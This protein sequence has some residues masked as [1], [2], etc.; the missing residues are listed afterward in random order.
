MSRRESARYERYE[1]RLLE[2]L[3]MLLLDE[4]VMA[5]EHGWSIVWRRSGCPQ[6]H[7]LRPTV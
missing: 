5:G 2:M 6:A 1:G 7:K 4:L 3:F